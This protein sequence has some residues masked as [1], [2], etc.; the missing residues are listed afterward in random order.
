MNQKK[1]LFDPTPT[2]FPAGSPIKRETPRPVEYREVDYFDKFDDNTVFFDLFHSVC[3]KNIFAVC[4]PML[5]FENLFLEGLSSQP[6]NESAAVVSNHK[7]N[8]L[9]VIEFETESQHQQ[10][11]SFKIADMTFKTSVST[12]SSDIFV[13]KNV[14]VTHQKNN[15]LGW[16]QY[17]I[18]FYSK[19][20]AANAFLIFDNGS[21]QYSAQDL[22]NSIELPKNV[23]ILGVVNWPFKFGPQAVD[24]PY[25]DSDFCQYGALE[26]AR[27][28][29]LAKSRAVL[30]VD[31]DELV[32][33]E[34]DSETI[35][36]ATANVDAE[37]LSFTGVWIDNFFE[38]HNDRK[39][40]DHREFHFI[41]TSA[42]QC[43]TKYI[44]NPT[45][46]RADALIQ[47]HDLVR[48]QTHW[49]EK[50][51]FRHFRGISTNWKDNRSEWQ[52]SKENR[53][54]DEFWATLRNES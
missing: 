20:H 32:I 50:F 29:F 6:A 5:N 15:D 31:I 30:S 41:D 28:R 35:F 34:L 48:A 44:Y 37:S 38:T 1:L 14:V 26:T 43:A 11:L 42:P 8:R 12:N 18:N 52:V 9:Q 51:R 33:N 36:D 49:T 23:E 53:V 7:H 10:F 39:P 27:R 2:F 3:G 13:G 4:P 17:W 46:L 25:W 21:G 19:F 22:L 16:I 40:I 47:L 54:Y 24:H 45:Q